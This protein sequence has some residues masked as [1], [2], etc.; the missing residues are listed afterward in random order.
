MSILS[1]T[2]I[3]VSLIGVIVILLFQARRNIRGSLALLCLVLILASVPL[4]MPLIQAG[5]A[6]GDGDD[7]TWFIIV[8]YA[9][10]LLGMLAQHAYARFSRPRRWRPKFDVGIFLAPIFASPIVFIP[11]LA[12]VQ[13]S[14]V[15][16][17]EADAARF[18]L[19]LVAFE[20]GFF[21]KTIFDQRHQLHLQEDQGQ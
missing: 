14:G 11:L 3:V 4:S 2:L 21:W 12:T 17:Y 18:M 7:E 10:L 16:L 8:L 1:F 13:T 15:D 20:N 19:F 9:F 5:T 6:R